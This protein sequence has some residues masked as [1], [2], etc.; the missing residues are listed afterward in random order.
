M[1]LLIRVDPEQRMNRW[2]R[3]HVQATLFDEFAVVCV[4]GSRET[5][6]QQMRAIPAES[7][8]EAQELAA[9]IV[10]EK[11]ARGY[12]LLGNT[13]RLERRK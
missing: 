8:A 11:I 3:V 7:L 4:W 12:A 1:T 6:F 9:R 13:S 5:A 10:T 2:Y